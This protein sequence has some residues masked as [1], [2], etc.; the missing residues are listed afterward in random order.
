MLC[1]AFSFSAWAP[2]MFLFP[3]LAPLVR[4]LAYLLP[5]KGVLRLKAARATIVSIVA[6]LIREQRDALEVATPIPYARFG[7][8]NMPVQARQT[9]EVRS[10]IGFWSGMG[11]TAPGGGGGGGGGAQGR[12]GVLRGLST[13][14]QGQSESG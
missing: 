6:S 7:Q 1:A 2:V 11:N 13:R 3:F 8:G 10:R 12:R 9:R 5:D 14:G 4:V